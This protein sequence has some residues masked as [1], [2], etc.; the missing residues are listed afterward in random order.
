MASYIQHVGVLGMKW[1]RRKAKTNS[2]YAK[3]K[4]KTN[5]DYAKR[6]AKT[7][8]DYAKT[9]AKSTAKVYDKNSAAM[10]K[11]ERLVARAKAKKIALIKQRELN[12]GVA[13]AQRVLRV[14][15]FGMTAA[16][17]LGLD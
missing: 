10:K 16:N 9:K 7:N 5:S 3:R 6:K 4:A 12:T 15:G 13:N 2:D 8:L 17:M 11:A 1:G 14:Y